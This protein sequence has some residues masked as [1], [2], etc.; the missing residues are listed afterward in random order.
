MLDISVF[1]FLSFMKNVENM[2]KRFHR[3]GGK[4]VFLSVILY[5]KRISWQFL[6][7]VHDL[8]LNLKVRN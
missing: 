4:H 8:L 7:D 6:N 2:V 5:T 3:F 1:N